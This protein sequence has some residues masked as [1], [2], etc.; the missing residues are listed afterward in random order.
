MYANINIAQRWRAVYVPI[1]ECTELD[2][3]FLQG[4]G[5][6]LTFNFI[7]IIVLIQLYGSPTQSTVDCQKF[8]KRIMIV[9]SL[10]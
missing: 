8:I 7:V 4:R 9:F 1:P 10:K 6:L 2:Y 3:I 5:L